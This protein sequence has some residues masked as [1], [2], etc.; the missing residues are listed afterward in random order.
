MKT[1]EVIDL[2]GTQAV[3]LPD[4]FRFDGESVRISRQ[5]DAV[6]LQPMQKAHWPA[7]FFEDIRIEDPAFCRPDQGQT[8]AAPVLT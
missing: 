4:G 8:P 6:I 1:A 7:M 3:K 5:G 2:Q